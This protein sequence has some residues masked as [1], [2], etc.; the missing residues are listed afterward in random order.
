MS[1][2][3]RVLFYYPNEEEV[4]CGYF[5]DCNVAKEQAHLLRE[6]FALKQEITGCEIPYVDYEDSD[7]NDASTINGYIENH[8]TAIEFYRKRNGS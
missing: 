5:D 4:V 8:K 1:K 2:I 3:Y 6:S 7:L